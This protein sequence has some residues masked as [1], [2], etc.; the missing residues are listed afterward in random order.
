MNLSKLLDTELIREKGSIL[1][2]VFNKPHEFPV[3]WSFKIP[4]S[5][6]HN[7]ITG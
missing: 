6:G 4:I 5:Y 1:M 3:H 2:Q 7:A